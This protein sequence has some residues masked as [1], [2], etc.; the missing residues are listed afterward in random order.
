VLTQ[1]PLVFFCNN[2]SSFFFV[3]CGSVVQKE[4]RENVLE[5]KDVVGQEGR[6]EDGRS[7]SSSRQDVVPRGESDVQAVFGPLSTIGSIKSSS[8]SSTYFQY[9]ATEETHV[10]AMDVVIKI[11]TMNATSLL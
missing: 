5:R 4:M 11:M 3:V 7:S 8:S 9:I 6:S 1:L 10:L 2:L